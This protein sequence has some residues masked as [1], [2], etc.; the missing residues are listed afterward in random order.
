M[1]YNN[2]GS[3]LKGA[4]MSISPVN[5]FVQNSYT[6]NGNKYKK[7]NVA[8]T[9]FTTAGIAGAGLVAMTAKKSGVK[10]NAAA[11]TMLMSVLNSLGLGMIVDGVINTILSHNADKKAETAVERNACCAHQG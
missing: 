5:L 9:V 3:V 8:K 11:L 6:N 7:S 10:P 1:C 4:V 2:I